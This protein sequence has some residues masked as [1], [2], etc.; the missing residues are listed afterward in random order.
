MTKENDINL[1]ELKKEL[2]ETVNGG[3]TEEELAVMQADAARNVL[4]DEGRGRAEDVI[5]A[6]DAP[7]EVDSA[8]DTDVPPEDASEEIVAVTDEPLRAVTLEEQELEAQRQKAAMQEM[9]A[10]EQAARSETE[11]SAAASGEVM[12]N[13]LPEGAGID[14]LTAKV[15]ASQE[16]A[17]REAEQE[18]IAE[19]NR[20]KRRRRRAR[21]ARNFFLT[22]LLLAVVAGIGGGAYL[23][24]ANYYASHFLTGTVINGNDVSRMTTA[25]VKKE[26]FGVTDTY[27]LTIKERGD[28]TETLSASQLGR[29]YIDN[30]EVE[31]IMEEQDNMH[32]LFH[33]NEEK[34]YTVTFDMAYD[35]AMA[36]DAVDRLSCFTGGD[37]TPPRD[38][39]LTTNPDGTYTIQPEE[40]GNTLDEAKAKD[41][42][43]AAL[44]S[45]KAEVD[46]EENDCYLKPEVLSTDEALNKRMNA[47]NS[48]L[49]VD[50][51][52]KIGENTERITAETVRPYITDTGY[53]VI[54]A[55]DWVKTLVYGWGQKYDTFG[56]AREFTTHDGITINIP[57]GGDYG[58]CINKDKTI[59]E[60]TA[61]IL[62][63]ESGEREPVW[64]FKAMGW[65]N[66]DI[67]GTYCEVSI[68]EQHL[69]CYKDGQLVMDTDVVTGKMT[70][71]R[72]T[73]A[74]CFAIDGKKRDATLG[75]LDV[76]GY[77]SPVS[78]WLPF[79]GGQGLHD[80][81]W[82][83]SF[84]GDIYNTNGSHGCVNIPEEN[85]ET[86]FNALEIGNAV[87]VYDDKTPVDSV[88]AQSD[89]A[90]EDAAAGSEDGV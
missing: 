43:F 2:Q 18:A 45:A 67:T 75:R 68:P 64:L 36:R 30:D 24:M 25:E 23:Y 26:L 35:K 20:A 11:A 49:A 41:L 72:R 70:A 29:S 27:A 82:R 77:A 74:G 50:L 52:Y 84:G 76:Q 56:L 28:V 86:I 63:G 40:Q 71:E 58:W 1:E 55:T 38:A 65:D 37:I 87:I 12:Y 57:A 14:D 69:W 88:P 34:A 53:D 9:A 42:I 39:R 17:A 62:A 54:M 13:T 73:I 79:N 5:V 83:S 22:I 6:K 85:M 16:K 59:E 80:A 61:A 89:P 48:Y 90:E 32:W 21:T 3:F 19:A 7:E 78:F 44:D 60:V 33:M 4:H 66:N 47:W 46:F 15:I 31:Q 51:T 8:P 10:R 81:P